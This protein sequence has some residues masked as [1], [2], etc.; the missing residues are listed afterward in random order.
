MFERYPVIVYP[1]TKDGRR[2][3]NFTITD[4]LTRVK[5]N[6]SD[7]DIDRIT[8]VYTILDGETPEMV[9]NKIY[10]TPFYHW[11]VMFVNEIYDYIGEWFKSDDI[12]KQYC[13]DRYGDTYLDQYMIVDDEFRVVYPDGV[14]NENTFFSPGAAYSFNDNPL[15]NNCILSYTDTLTAVSAYDVEVKLNEERRTIKVIKPE[16]VNAFIDKFNDKLL[17]ARI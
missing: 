1:L 16:A 6:M 5:F 15:I 4:I 9:S 14:L 3:T 13:I 11:I 12:L 2:L 7:F 17:E 8:N 10:G